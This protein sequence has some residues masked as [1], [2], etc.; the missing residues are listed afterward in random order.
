MTRVKPIYNVIIFVSF[1]VYLSYRS[2]K[3]MD[4]KTRMLVHCAPMC[5]ILMSVL[6]VY[7]QIYFNYYNKNIIEKM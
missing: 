3:L 5:V 4:L 7:D 6:S 1:K 2:I